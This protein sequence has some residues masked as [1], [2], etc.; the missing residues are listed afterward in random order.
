M[1]EIK[2]PFDKPGC[3]TPSA[4]GSWGG[5]KIHIPDGPAATPSAGLGSQKD[6]VDVPGGDAGS[7]EKDVTTYTHTIKTEK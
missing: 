5:G 3:P 2:T 6:F 7:M 1:S 4:D